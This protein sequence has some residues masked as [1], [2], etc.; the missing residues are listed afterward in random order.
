MTSR[1]AK[2]VTRNFRTKLESKNRGLE[3]LRYTL[4]VIRMKFD[5]VTIF[6]S[7]AEAY[8]SEGVIARA[9][10][11][12]IISLNAYNL[13][14]WAVDKHKTVDERP[15]GGGPGMVL[16]LEPIYRAV[17]ELKSQGSKVKT[18]TQ[19]SKVILT[20]ARGKRFTQEKAREYSKLDQLII[21][22]GRYEGVDERVAEYIADE[23]ISVGDYVLSGGELA[24]MSMVDAVARLVPGVLGNE[25]SPENALFPQYTR[26][27]EFSPNGKE[28]WTVPDVLLTG[29]HKRIKQWRQEHTFTK[30]KAIF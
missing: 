13:R 22:C 15:F 10:E 29:D 4:H 19:K 30:S 5:I 7:V 14:D 2:R 12:G 23:S 9:R 27:E 25:E 1:N 11:A 24:A 17:R 21:I 3:I 8:F 26:P 20:S 16:K 6:P 18:T 28:K